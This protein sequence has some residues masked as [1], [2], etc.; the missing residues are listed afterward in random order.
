LQFLHSAG[1][2]ARFEVVTYQRT[3]FTFSTAG[4]TL[5]GMWASH[6]PDYSF[7]ADWARLWWFGDIDSTQ[8]SAWLCLEELTGRIV[9]VDVDR[10]DPLFVVD[11]SV[12]ALVRCMGLIHSFAQSNDGSLNRV[13]ALV[14]ALSNDLDLARGEAGHFWLPLI[15]AAIESGCGRLEVAVE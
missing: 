13:E 9:A 3:V 15:E 7:P 10:E 2:P 4:K 14:D 5:A 8:A 6:M 1:L 12:V 11:T